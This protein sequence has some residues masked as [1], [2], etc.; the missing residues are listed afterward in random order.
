[1][2][3]LTP[4]QRVNISFLW[5]FLGGKRLLKAIEWEARSAKETPGGGQGLKRHTMNSRFIRSIPESFPRARMEMR[6]R[7][8]IRVG[9]CRRRRRRIHRRRHCAAA[10]N[11]I[12]EHVVVDIMRW[13]WGRGSGAR[14]VGREVG[15]GSFA[16]YS[17]I[18]D[19]CYFF[20]LF[21]PQHVGF[22][23]E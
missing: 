5:K 18:Y 13:G 21:F 19:V 17:H 3:F 9:N 4:N 22:N 6:R 8:S 2:L 15:G 1:M 10:A 23:E 20:T 16:L 14:G 7:I 12:R 11:S